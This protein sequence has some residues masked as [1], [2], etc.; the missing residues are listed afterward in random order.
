MYSAAP[1]AQMDDNNNGQRRLW[2]ELGGREGGR[3]EA[4]TTHL[5]EN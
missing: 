5:R 2:S 1:F 4:E 3:G